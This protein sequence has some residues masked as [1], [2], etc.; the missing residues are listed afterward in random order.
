MNQNHFYKILI[1]CIV[2][3]LGIDGLF[4]VVHKPRGKHNEKIQ[5]N[6]NEKNRTY[7]KLSDEGLT[8]KSIGNKI[9]KGDSIKIGIYSR[10]VKSPTGKKDKNYGFT[11]QIENQKPVTLKYKKPG[12][13]VTSEDRPGWIYT[14]SGFWFMYLPKKKNGYKIKIKPL[15]GNSVVYLR[16][17]SNAIV[18]EGDFSQILKTVNRQDRWRIITQSENS[19]KREKIRYYYPLRNNHQLQY[20]IKGPST[21][22]VFSRIEFDNGQNA[23]DYILRIREDGFDLGNYYFTTEKSEIS[24]VGKTGKTVSKWRSVWLNIPE[25]RHFYTITLPENLKS[26]QNKTVYIRLKEWTKK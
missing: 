9:E 19:E 17:T 24:K 8:Y 21:V 1:S 13:K 2:L 26:N 22:K 23:E 10:S 18:K 16:L 4:G 3:H 7:Y 14:K 20:E 15:K 11:I 25:G 12:S 6:I 5:L